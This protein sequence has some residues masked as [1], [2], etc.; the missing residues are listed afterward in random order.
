MAKQPSNALSVVDQVCSSLK[1]GDKFASMLPQCYRVSA[2][3]WID[4]GKLY[5]LTSK[6]SATLQRCTAQSLLRSFMQ[7]AEAGIPI[8][9]KMGYLVPYGDQA[10][11]MA[12]YIGL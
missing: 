6:N 10:T 1:A 3:R 11:F 7:A 8:D 2:E 9:G 12:S 4:R 5:I